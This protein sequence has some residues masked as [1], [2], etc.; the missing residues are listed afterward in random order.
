MKLII[1]KLFHATLLSPQPA[2]PKVCVGRDLIKPDL[3][4]NI[5]LIYCHNNLTMHKH[6]NIP[7]GT[8]PVSLSHERAGCDFYYV[9]MSEDNELHAIITCSFKPTKTSHSADF[10]PCEIYNR[11]S[12]VLPRSL[13]H[14]SDHSSKTDPDSA[15]TIPAA[16][17]MKIWTKRQTKEN[18]KMYRM[19]ES[20]TFPF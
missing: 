3:L 16:I 18:K 19:S 20:M 13:S 7:T 11:K 17:H 4:I 5:N 12:F 10:V 6:T 9:F 1:T 14:F 8:F 15:T 2:P